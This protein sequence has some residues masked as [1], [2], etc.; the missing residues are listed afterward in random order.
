VGSQTR[1]T[2][3]AKLPQRPVGDLARLLTE[4]A[5]TVIDEPLLRRA[6]TH[7]SYAYENGGVPHNERQE[8]LG[9]SV[10]GL[11]VTDHLYAEH[12]DLPEG[13]LAKLRA[14]VVNSRALARV[15]RELELG[16]FVLLGR[17]EMGTGG[18]DKD[19]ILA[20]TMEAV[21]GTVYLAGGLEASGRFVHHI[22]DGMLVQATHLGAG[23][24]WKTS[25]QEA[26]AA[27]DLGS[28]TYVVTDV[29][30]DHDKLFTA[31]VV[32]ADEVLGA[33][34]GRNKKTAEQEAA[35]Q[36]WTTLRDRAQQTDES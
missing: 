35:E 9:D 11:V 3:R 21:I 6:L 1:R 34:E 18:R 27:A 13:Q 17:G 31:K 30:P 36:A 12:P 24:D 23:L 22:L 26:V 19:S 8:F 7:R 2:R 15:A 33:G 28:P 4:I 5:G 32:I 29:G 10:L 25:L 20:D 16:D 14:S